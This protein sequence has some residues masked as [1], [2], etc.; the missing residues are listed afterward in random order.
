MRLCLPT[1]RSCLATCVSAQRARLLYYVSLA[2][3]VVRGSWG[4][5]CPPCFRALVGDSWGC[6][7]P[8]CSRVLLRYVVRD[9][10]GCACPRCFRVVVYF[11]KYVVSLCGSCVR[12]YIS[13]IGGCGTGC[14]CW[15]VV[16]GN[17]IDPHVRGYARGIVSFA[18]LYPP[19]T[20]LFVTTYRSCYPFYEYVWGVCP[21]GRCNSTYLICHFGCS[22]WLFIL[23]VHFSCPFL[24]FILVVHFGCSFWM[25]V[26]VV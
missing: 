7:C 12:Q 4:C 26:L 19:C 22:F 15:T 2:E 1:V 23:V 21:D 20:Y 6:A 9:S 10:W 13:F 24:L 17:A 14:A 25:S 5:A 3:S 18:M 16:D 8:L 11:S